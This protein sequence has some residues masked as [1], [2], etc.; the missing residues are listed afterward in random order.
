MPRILLVSD[1]H[2]EL[3]HLL[4]A[5]DVEQ[6][7]MLICAGDWGDPGTVPE[8]VYHQIIHRLPVV[9]VYGNHDDQ[10]LLQSLHNRDG[11]PILVPHGEIIE[12]LGLRIAG[13]S[14]IWAKSHKKPHY[15]LAEEVIEAA[16][17][18]AEHDDAHVDIWISHGCPIGISDFT[19][20]GTHGGQRC[21]LD[22][23]KIVQPRLYVCGHLHRPQHRQLKSG[24][25]IINV[26]YT[27]CGDYAV[28]NI[29]AQGCILEKHVMASAM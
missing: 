5:L 6:P 11:T 8:D 9:T 7:D 14:G 27:A 18:V 22:A 10:K 21:F 20:K 4:K 17:N 1:M 25:I 15:I 23:F 13:V 3:S 29:D 16:Q 12:L 26:G 2:G 19:H 24:A 28:V